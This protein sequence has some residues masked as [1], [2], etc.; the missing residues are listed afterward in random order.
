MN[1]GAM[2]RYQIRLLR[3]FLIISSSGW[4]THYTTTCS[5]PPLSRGDLLRS[6]RG[7]LLCQPIICFLLGLFQGLLGGHGSRDGCLNGSL[8]GEA[9][10]RGRPWVADLGKGILVQDCIC[11]NEFTNGRDRIG[12]A[13]N[14]G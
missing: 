7:Y 1:V 2:K 12:R 10:L 11:I 13:F 8:Q 14:D 6:R 5:A 4:A 3:S 9:R